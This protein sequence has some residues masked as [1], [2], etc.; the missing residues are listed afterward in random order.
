MI[1]SVLIVSPLLTM[2]LSWGM[3]V[4]VL[5]PI[6]SLSKSARSSAE[7]AWFSTKKPISSNSTLV[8]KSNRR[9]LTLDV[10]DRDLSEE[11]NFL[12]MYFIDNGL[13]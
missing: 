1:C 9:V 12:G 2:T 11:V 13:D 8:D 3:I 4:V 6:L 10:G 7:I 5:S